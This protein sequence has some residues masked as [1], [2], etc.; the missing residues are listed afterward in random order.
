MRSINLGTG[1]NGLMVAVERA[2]RLGVTVTVLTVMMKTNVRR[3]P[4]IAKVAFAAGAHYRVNVYQPVMTDAFTL[5]H[6]EFWDGF[7]R[8]LAA[9]RLVRTTEPILN[10]M[11]GEPFKNGSG[12]GRQTMRITPRGDIVRACTGTSPTFVSKTCRARRRR[13]PRLSAVR[14]RPPGAGRVP[15]LPVCLDLSGRLLGEAR[16]PAGARREG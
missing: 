9:A 4:E 5:T 6:E 10:A 8:L 14:T 13:R 15:E 3:L 2:Q 12:C 7:R 1:E 16:V 11:L